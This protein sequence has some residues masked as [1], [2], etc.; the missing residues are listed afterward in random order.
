M[1]PQ[2]SNIMIMPMM[3]MMMN[4]MCGFCCAQKSKALELFAD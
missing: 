3:R 4:V 1:R 2:Y